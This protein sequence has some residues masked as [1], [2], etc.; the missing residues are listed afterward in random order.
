MEMNYTIFLRLRILLLAVILPVIFLVQG[1]YGSFVFT[2]S[3]PIIWQVALRGMPFHSLG[4]R[5]RPMWQIIV[6]GGLTGCLLGVL[7]G[8]VLRWLGITGRS[9]SNLHAVQLTFGPW[10]A[11]FSLYNELGYRLLGASGSFLGSCIYLAFSILVIGLGEELFWRGF[12]QQKIN[13]YLSAR[14]AIFVTSILFALIHFYV[15]TIL[16]LRSGSALLLLIAI[17][18]GAWGFLS[19]K[20]GSIWPSAVSHGIAA[21]IIWKYFFFA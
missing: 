9:F 19:N 8:E 12:I 17:A 6:I 3:I 7:G 1:I 21:F 2:F 15:F 18:G 11:S 16:D 20:Y 5:R 14:W 4:L 13:R 10:S